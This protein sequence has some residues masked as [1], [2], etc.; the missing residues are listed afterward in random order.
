MFLKWFSVLSNKFLHNLPSNF[1][2]I[3]SQNSPCPGPTHPAQASFWSVNSV[4][5]MTQGWYIMWFSSFLVGPIFITEMSWNFWPRKRIY[6]LV[7]SRLCQAISDPITTNNMQFQAKLILVWRIPLT[8]M[9]L[10]VSLNWS[11]EVHGSLS[12]PLQISHLVLHLTLKEKSLYK[13]FWFGRRLESLK[14]LLVQNLDR[15]T[16]TVC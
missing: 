6:L 3:V 12:W 11:P 14:D 7:M 4:L 13:S 1:L 5:W 15:V 10:L 9:V 16:V 8:D 2:H